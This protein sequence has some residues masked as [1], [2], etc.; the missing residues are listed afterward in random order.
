M[1]ITSFKEM[2]RLT[3]Q[4][5]L[6]SYEICL[7][8]S[9]SESENDIIEDRTDT[10]DDEEREYE[11]E[12]ENE[13]EIG[14]SIPC[15]CILEPSSELALCH[16]DIRRQDVVKEAETIIVL[17]NTDNLLTRSGTVEMLAVDDTLNPALIQNR[18]IIYGRQTK[19][20]PQPPFIWYD[21]PSSTFN[22][23][24]EFDACL[25]DQPREELSVTVFFKMI[26]NLDIVSSIVIYTNLRIQQIDT[27]KQKN[28]DYRLKRD[29]LIRDPITLIE[30]Y[31]FIGLLLLFGLTG[32]TT[33][34]IEELW[35]ESSI[36][37]SAFASA[38]MSRDRFQLINKNICF[39]DMSTRSIRKSDKF[40]KMTEI[41]NKFKRNLNLIIPSY[42]LCIDEELY[43]FRGKCC[44]RQ[45][46]PSKPARYGIKYWCLV[47]TK[48][49][50][51]LTIFDSFIFKSSFNFEGY[52]VDVNIY[53]GKSTEASKREVKIGEKAV[54]TLCEPFFNSKRCITADNF[55]SSISLCQELWSKK[56]EYI[57]TL[58]C[59]K[60]DIPESFL[61][62]KTRSEKSSLFAFKD[63]LTLT[64]YVPKK[65][66]S[67]I[68]ISSKHHDDKIDST[69]GKPQIIID[70]NKFKGIF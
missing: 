10:D 48:S 20:K 39:D 13:N 43:S 8:D 33:I 37:Y 38:C 66:K 36:H 60:T 57:G 17:T 30:I 26:I 49:G 24:N 18:N 32:K 67:V 44:F 58:R 3:A 52:L 45:F 2:S 69:S 19:T 21:K 54:L 62:S 40:H 15:A 59:N 64:S 41:F 35:C 31:A 61:K 22:N 46:I 63:Y 70:Y 47:D 28:A 6:Q 34:S 68:L 27:T 55:F 7:D 12:V 4:Q 25:I 1:K 50:N 56:L 9:C 5:I 14:N 42:S 65:N 29:R 23:S 53:L 16:P 51:S 11:S